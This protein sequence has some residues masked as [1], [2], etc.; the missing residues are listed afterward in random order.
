[1][2]ALAN[3]I[4]GSESRKMSAIKILHYFLPLI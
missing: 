2:A 4:K 1:M 3:P